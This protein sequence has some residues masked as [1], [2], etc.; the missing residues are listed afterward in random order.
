LDV[1]PQRPNSVVSEL[2]GLEGAVLK[3]VFPE[4][5]RGEVRTT[6]LEILGSPTGCG[7]AKDRALELNSSKSRRDEIR[8]VEIG[9]ILCEGGTIKREQQGHNHEYQSL[10]HFIYP[11]LCF[12]ALQS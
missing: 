3:A 2:L 11:K 1:E 5:N 6:E 7:T 12:L 10:S 4:A 8:G 9:S